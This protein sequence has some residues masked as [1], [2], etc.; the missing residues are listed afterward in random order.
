M[1]VPF[2]QSQTHGLTRCETRAGP[3]DLRHGTGQV[4]TDSAGTGRV[5][6]RTRQQ[7]VIIVPAFHPAGADSKNRTY[8]P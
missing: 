6:H 3:G 2:S 1:A 4:S 8:V 5:L 7:A